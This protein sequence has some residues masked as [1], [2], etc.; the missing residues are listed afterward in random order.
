MV[1]REGGQQLFNDLAPS[2]RRTSPGGKQRLIRGGGH[3]PGSV[4]E[5]DPRILVVVRC[6]S[7]PGYGHD[8]ADDSTNITVGGLRSGEVRVSAVLVDVDRK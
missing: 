1:G 6:R 7:L 4:M 2:G 3:P 8:A 5:L